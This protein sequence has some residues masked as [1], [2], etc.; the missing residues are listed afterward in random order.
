MRGGIFVKRAFLLYLVFMA[1]RMFSSELVQELFPETFDWQRVTHKHYGFVDK[2]YASVRMVMPVDMKLLQNVSAH[3]SLFL[4]ENTK[5]IAVFYNSKQDATIIISSGKDIKYR[6]HQE[7][8][9]YLTKTIPGIILLPKSKENEKLYA[10]KLYDNR[11]RLV[12]ICTL[13]DSLVCWEIN[14]EKPLSRENDHSLFTYM[15]HFSSLQF[16]EYES[17]DIGDIDAYSVYLKSSKDRNLDL[18]CN[19]ITKEFDASQKSPQIA[20]FASKLLWLT[21]DENKFSEQTPQRIDLEIYS[22]SLKKLAKRGYSLALRDLGFLAV[23]YPEVVSPKEVQKLM[24]KEMKKKKE[25]IYQKLPLFCNSL[26]SWEKFSGDPF[27]QKHL[28]KGN[29]NDS[30]TIFPNSGKEFGNYIFDFSEG[31]SQ[32]TLNLDLKKHD[33]YESC[34]FLEEIPSKKPERNEI[35]SSEVQENVFGVGI[36]QDM[37]GRPVRYITPN[38]RATNLLQVKPN[39]YGLGIGMDQFGRPI[40]AVPHN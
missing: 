38:G 25:K 10:W 9:E 35:F 3:T 1:F 12:I 5:A 19:F 31:S 7:W 15:L 34:F 37:Y 14:S 4:I 22:Y 2:K 20:Y 24:D 39:A 29:E 28:G 18:L 13:N 17:Y 30:K 23:R 36:H 26:K 27:Q 21:K 11:Q 33:T 40:K 8:A 6:T 16:V 32:K